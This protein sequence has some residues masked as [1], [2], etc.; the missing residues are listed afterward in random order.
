M[1]HRTRRLKA[2]KAKLES[3]VAERTSDLKRTQDD[4]VRMERTAAVGKLTQ[5]LIDRILNPINYINNFSKLTSGL[6]QDLMADIED[7]KER[8]SEDCYEDCS[9]IIQMMKTNLK[10]IEDHGISTTRTLR[11]MEAM[12]NSH[13]G[14]MTQH[15]LISLCRQTVA[16]VSE[17]HKDAI[18]EYGIKLKCDMPNQ[19]MIVNI[20]AGSIKNALIAL[21]NNS[22]YSVA[23]KV[24]IGPPGYIP[25]IVLSLPEEGTGIIIRDNGMGIGENII[26]K[27]FDPFFTTKPTGEAAG[28][29][30]YLVRNIINDHHG[31]IS[32]ESQQDEYCQ[33]TITL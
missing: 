1:L 21:F 12:L 20:D 5:G 3:L 18:A 30:L 6:A 22:I 9:D 23:K 26:N 32:V 19:Q 16:V 28:V 25:E 17:Y 13:I 8:I 10:K 14:T 24:R 27:V 11:A 7:E 33:F 31:K 4:L 15:D 2:E 29:G